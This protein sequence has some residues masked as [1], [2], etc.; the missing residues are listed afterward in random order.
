M[1]DDLWFKG[2]RSQNCETMWN[3][4]LWSNHWGS[5]MPSQML[6]DSRFSAIHCPHIWPILGQT[7]SQL[8]TNHNG[9]LKGFRW[10]QRQRTPMYTSKTFKNQ[11]FQFEI[12]IFQQT[13]RCQIMPTQ[14]QVLQ[15]FPKQTNTLNSIEKHAKTTNH[16]T[17]KHASTGNMNQYDALM[18]H[19]WSRMIHCFN[20]SQPRGNSSWAPSGPSPHSIWSKD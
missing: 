5:E 7:C 16:S 11:H 2:C 18:M 13:Y 20:W 3:M 14:C 8:T 10:P 9:T 19:W 15:P 1:A 12:S 4:G 6:L 17:S